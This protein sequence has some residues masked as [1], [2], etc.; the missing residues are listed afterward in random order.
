MRLK[1]V[2][3]EWVDSMT[4]GAQ[5]CSKDEVKR[6]SLAQLQ[7]RSIGW[8]I[9]EDAGHITIVQSVHLDEHGEIAEYGQPLAVPRVSIADLR[10]LRA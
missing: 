7:C 10:I 8:L 6:Y 9:D 5:W 3:F 2:E 4:G 1:R